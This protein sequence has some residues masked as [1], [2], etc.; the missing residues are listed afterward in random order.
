[1]IW[2]RWRSCKL[3]WLKC[4][5]IGRHWTWGFL[6]ALAFGNVGHRCSQ[7]QG[8]TRMGPT[9]MPISNATAI[10]TLSRVEAT[11]ARPHTR[12]NFSLSFSA[13]ALAQPARSPKTSASASPTASSPTMASRRFSIACRSATT[14]RPGC[15]TP[16][17]RPTSILGSAPKPRP[18]R[19]Q[20]AHWPATSG[21]T[22]RSWP[23]ST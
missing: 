3:P 21:A 22:R 14:M 1:M 8:M 20:A 7:V 4:R 15:S 2:R 13:S 11:L 9:S 18:S 12:K 23:T 17:K 16:F 5:L 6:K 19:P 10:S